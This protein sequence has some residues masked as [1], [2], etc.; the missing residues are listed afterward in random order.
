VASPTTIKKP[1][2]GVSAGN[3]YGQRFGTTGNVAVAPQR[4]NLQ[5]PQLDVLRWNLPRL[6]ETPVHSAETLFRS[7]VRLLLPQP[8]ASGQCW[9]LG[10]DVAADFALIFVG[11]FAASCLAEIAGALSVP[12]WVACLRLTMLQASLF[13]LLGYT[14]RLYQGRTIESARDERLIVGKCVFWSTLLAAT[15]YGSCSSLV[16]GSCVNVLFLLARR[17]WRRVR[18]NK[19][20][21]DREIKNVL[22]V[23]SG[24]TAR[25]LADHLRRSRFARQSVLGFVDD[26][27][28]TGQGVLGGV[29]D[30]P[31]LIKTKFVDE[32]ILAGVEKDVALRAIAEARRCRVDIKV[33]PECF[34]VAPEELSIPAFGEVPVLTLRSEYVPRL[35]QAI[36]RMVDIVCSALGLFLLS[37]LLAGVAALVRW[38]SPGPVLFKAQRVGFKGRRFVCYKFRTMIIDADLRK[39]ELRARNERQGASFKIHDDPRVTRVGRV[40]RRY[41]LDELPQMWNVLRG[42]MSLVGPRPHP[43]DDFA[44]YGVDDLERLQAIPGLTGLW[45]VTARRDPSFERN[46]A[47]D[48]EYIEHWSLTTDFRI[49]AKTISAVL[50]GSGT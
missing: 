30:L 37:P 11:S 23:G 7:A 24:E 20:D 14:E 49:M 17:E 45:Q 16:A 22:I 6:R 28:A 21:R 9:R 26:A 12:A 32:I 3:V 29:Q 44:R 19:L 25:K 41:S 48:R 47:L 43:L 40:L 1:V 36:K 5:S 42:E 2:Q 13:T 50:Q 10:V 8:A 38:D 46:V 15:I 27:S 31:Y 39:D 35:R 18:S 33:V 4:K 34:G